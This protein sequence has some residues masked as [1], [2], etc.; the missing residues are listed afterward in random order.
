[1]IFAFI[2]NFPIIIDALTSGGFRDFLIEA[3][4]YYIYPAIAALV[5]TNIDLF[6]IYANF[7]KRK[8]PTVLSFVALIYNDIVCIIF[9]I[10][11]YIVDIKNIYFT[12][13]SVLTIP[14]IT[15]MLSTVFMIDDY[16]DLIKGRYTA[17]EQKAKKGTL[18]TAEIPLELRTSTA[19]VAAANAAKLAIP[20]L[21]IHS[22]NAAAA[23]EEAEDDSD[24]DNADASEKS[25]ENTADRNTAVGGKPQ[26]QPAP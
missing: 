2:V 25:T 17:P 26:E 24:T 13:Q 3:K 22:S 20:E 18:Q 19:E 10:I 1:M 21:H 6:I 23:K 14:I 9:F 7:M 5:I 15:I 12:M 8:F 11:V 16:I 4:S